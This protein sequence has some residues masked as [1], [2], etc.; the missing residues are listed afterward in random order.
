MG[1]DLSVNVQYYY[2][3]TNLLKINAVIFK[4]SNLYET[5]KNGNS[6]NSMTRN[7]VN[8]CVYYYT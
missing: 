1:F 2:G 7:E 6:T 4:T 8:K 3:S 5:C